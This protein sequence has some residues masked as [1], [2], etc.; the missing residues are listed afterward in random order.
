MTRVPESVMVVLVL[1]PLRYVR[2]LATLAF[3]RCVV[4]KKLLGFAPRAISVPNTVNDLSPYW[5]ISC[6]N[7]EK[8]IAPMARRLL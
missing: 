8:L 3:L 7:S 2:L 4:L 5:L 6:G 1:L